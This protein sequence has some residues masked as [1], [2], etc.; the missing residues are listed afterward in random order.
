MPRNSGSIGPS[1]QMRTCFGGV[2]TVAPGDGSDRLRNA[3]AQAPASHKSRAAHA[4]PPAIWAAR[5]DRA[6]VAPLE[7]G[8]GRG[9][10]D[11]APPPL[12]SFAAISPSPHDVIGPHHIVVLVLQ[13]MAVEHV[14]ELVALSDR[15]APRQIEPR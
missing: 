12:S 13:D 1:N 5:F 14:P 3:C 6:L 10:R 4:K 7:P 15:R 8:C 9:G 11:A 2:A